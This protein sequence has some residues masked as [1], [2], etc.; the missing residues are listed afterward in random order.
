MGICWPFSVNQDGMG[1][2][3]NL[4]LD[5]INHEGLAGGIPLRLVMRD[6]RFD[7]ERNKQ[8][9]TEFAD[10]PNMSASIGYYDDSSAIKASTIFEPARLL[11]MIVGA[12]STSM[13]A[14]GF[15]YVVRT[16]VSSEKIARSLARMMADRGYKRVALIWEED[17]YGEGLAYQFNVSLNSLGKE[18]VYEWSYSREHPD[19]RLPVNELRGVNPDVIFFAGLE[20]WAGDFLRQA[21]SAGLTRDIVGAFSDT[22]EMRRR[23]GRGLEGAMYFEIYNP[24]STAPENHRFV[25]RYQARFHKPPDA[26]AAQGYDA[27]HILARAVRSTGS[28]NPLDLCYAIRFMTPWKGANGEYSFDERGEMKD[29]P[30]YL[31]MFRNGVSQVVQESVPDSTPPAR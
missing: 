24:D 12:N 8:I 4:A 15:R 28:S 7:W 18:L 31:N 1:D 5:E 11:N 23:A 26:W 14:R 16:T 19:F 30:I 3:L 25:E 21:R 20:P 27:L 10:T 9:A 13:T 6:D 2:G 17:A 22:P 29:K